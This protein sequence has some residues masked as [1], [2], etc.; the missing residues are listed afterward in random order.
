MSNTVRCAL[1]RFENER[2]CIKKNNKVKVNKPRHCVF[3]VES[4]DKLELMLERKK[5]TSKPEVT[6]R[7]DHV[8]DGATVREWDGT[9][10]VKVKDAAK[11]SALKAS[12]GI[13]DTGPAPNEVR[14]ESHFS[15][16]SK[17][18]L[19]GDLSRFFKSTVGGK[20]K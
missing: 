20:D 15:G 6:M 7:P 10:Y 16:D 3:Y 1:C 19:T 17:H 11:L 8:W 18:P 5:W 4:K 13:T 2:R 12:M 9:K 14:Q